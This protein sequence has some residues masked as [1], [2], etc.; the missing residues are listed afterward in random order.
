M[1]QPQASPS[2]PVE[3]K[4][5]AMTIKSEVLTELSKVLT[6]QGK[7]IEAGW[8][9]YRMGVLP[10]DCSQVQIDETRLAF[11]A[12]AQHLFASMMSILDPG[13]E[14]T[15]NDLKRMDLIHEE[16]NQFSASLSA[17]RKERN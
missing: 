14:P 10:G 13:A 15:E 7:I 1:T 4:G 9:G 16:L 3:K 11:F 8:T 2:S 17:Y 6:D 12:G 5:R